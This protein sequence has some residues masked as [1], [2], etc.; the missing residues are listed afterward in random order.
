MVAD[1]RNTPFNSRI[2]D[3]IT[4]FEV[5]EH[6]SDYHKYLCEIRRLLRENGF[7]IISTPYNTIPPR[8]KLLDPQH[9]REFTKTE[10]LSLL[11]EYFEVMEMRF[12]SRS[13]ISP[14]DNSILRK[15][16]LKLDFLNM[17]KL[18]SQELRNYIASKL[19]LVTLDML[20]SYHFKSLLVQ[21]EDKETL[22][23][24][25]VCQHKK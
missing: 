4:S 10:F 9:I 7:F 3:V 20:S 18:L 23:Q 25:A 2:F 24:I 21:F 15:M 6:I 19:G 13:D 11:S 17:R 1:L 5:I 22:I 8:E 12:Q 14:T 16:I